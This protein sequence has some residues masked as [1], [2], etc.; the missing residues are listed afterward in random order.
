MTSNIISFGAY[1]TWI[2]PSRL[3]AKGGKGGEQ[4]DDG[5]DHEGVTNIHVRGGFEGIQYIKLD[6]V[7]DGQPK[8]GSVHGVS[9]RGFTQP[10]CIGTLA[11][12][13]VNLIIF[14]VFT[15][16]FLFYS[17]SLRLTILTMNI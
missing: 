6:Y 5:T 10:V 9:G 11:F 12:L 2:S 1:F 13:I 14:F 8:V 16:L 4:W 15:M 3:E 7:K 17:C